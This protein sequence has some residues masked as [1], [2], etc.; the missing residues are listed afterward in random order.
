MKRNER[1]GRREQSRVCGHGQSGE[2]RKLR[3]IERGENEVN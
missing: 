3:D 2:E 1:A